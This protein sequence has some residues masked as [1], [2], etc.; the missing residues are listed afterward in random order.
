MSSGVIDDLFILRGHFAP[1]AEEMK[2]AKRWPKAALYGKAV[3]PPR[4]FQNFRDFARVAISDRGSQ[5]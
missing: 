2:R 4:D 3:Y 1:L 5:L